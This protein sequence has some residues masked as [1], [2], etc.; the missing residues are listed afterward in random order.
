MTSNTTAKPVSNGPF[1]FHNYGFNING[2]LRVGGPNLQ[3]MLFPDEM[4][5]VQAQKWARNRA[6]A[7]VNLPWL[8]AQLT[9]YDI[10]FDPGNTVAELT[11]LLADNVKHGRCNQLPIWIRAIASELEQ[12]FKAANPDLTS[13]IDRPPQRRGAQRPKGL[14]SEDKYKQIL[15]QFTTPVDLAN[16]HHGL[17]L[18]KYFLDQEGRPDPSKTPFLILLPG[19][20]DRLALQQAADAIP[21]LKTSSGGDGEFRILVIGWNRAA[22]FDETE[23]ISADQAR[24]RDGMSP[25][26]QKRLRCHHNMIKTLPVLSKPQRFTI[27]SAQGSYVIDSRGLNDNFPSTNSSTGYINIIPSKADGWI[28]IFE[29][30]IIRGVMR[31][32]TDRKALLARCKA[33]QKNKYRVDHSGML[34]PLEELGPTEEKNGASEEDD[35]FSD[36]EKDELNKAWSH[37]FGRISCGKRKIAP[38]EAASA[39]AKRPRMSSSSSINRIYFKWR[40]HIQG[41]CSVA[42]DGYK[43]N[44]GYLQFTD[45]HCTRFEGTISSIL[46]GGKNVPFRGFKV[47][48]DGGAEMRTYYSL[49]VIKNSCSEVKASMDGDTLV[50]R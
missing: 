44:A 42:Y 32:D 29:I 36:L 6:K 20:T 46:I 27:E 45:S 39:R 10:E 8:L 43:R 33:T 26:W 1:S 35:V 47:S 23:R 18:A 17:F 38:T 49:L 25:T 50:N 41:D 24:L 2:I 13:G 15:E 21:G 31:L 30:G 12:L 19:L 11:K 37:V 28:G 9:F 40:G 14:I 4:S 5:G 34:I 3:E 22:L 48:A 16:Y 7:T